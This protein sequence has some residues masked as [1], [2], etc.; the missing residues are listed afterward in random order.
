MQAGHFLKSIGV[1][2]LVCNIKSAA[3]HGNRAV[4]PE[5]VMTLL[6]DKR[7]PAYLAG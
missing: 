4:S 1:I 6:N 7:V 5:S 2:Y 3:G